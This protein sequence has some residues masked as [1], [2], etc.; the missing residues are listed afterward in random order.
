M[1]NINLFNFSWDLVNIW[2]GW[3]QYIKCS[4]N[5]T[6]WVTPFGKS[7]LT[8]VVGFVFP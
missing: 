4:I 5:I 1:T 2:W 7:Q 6:R 8:D 3:W